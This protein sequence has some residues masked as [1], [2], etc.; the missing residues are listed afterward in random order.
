MNK[1]AQPQKK[2]RDCN[3]DRPHTVGQWLNANPDA[4]RVFNAGLLKRQQHGMSSIAEQLRG[5]G[6]TFS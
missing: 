5:K 2:P 4:K 1:Q 3:V 6:R